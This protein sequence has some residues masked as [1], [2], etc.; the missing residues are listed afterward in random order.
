MKPPRH[1][2][3]LRVVAG[4]PNAKGR[5]KKLLFDDM[6]AL[7]AQNLTAFNQLPTAPAAK[8]K[9]LARSK[10]FSRTWL[11][12]LSDNRWHAL[13]P[14]LV[15]LWLVVWYRSSEG[16]K[17]VILTQK[18]MSE[19]GILGR[20]RYRY[21]RRLEASGVVRVVGWGQAATVVEVLVRPP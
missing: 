7:R 9:R 3:H 13:F 11:A 18:I 12:W 4:N 19:A 5:G 16:E 1:P 17:P 15:R 14:P 20:H 8:L 21:A 10:E 2:P 6:E